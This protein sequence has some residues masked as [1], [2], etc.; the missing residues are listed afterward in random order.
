MVKRALPLLFLLLTSPTFGAVYQIDI[1]KRLQGREGE[2]KFLLYKV[3]K[4][5][6]LLKIMKRF[7]VPRNLLYE[8][9]KLNKIKNPNRIYAGQVIKLPSFRAERSSRGR[10]L[11]DEIALLKRLGKVRESGILFTRSGK[12][13]LKENPLFEV[14]GENFVIDLSGKIGKRVREELKEA[15]FSVVKGSEIDSLIEKALS[16][17]FSS[18]EK[19]GKLILGE[20]DVL[21]YKFDFMGY[22]FKTGQRI[23]INKTPDTPPQLKRL[24]EAYGIDLI[25]PQ[26]RGPKTKEG[27]G[28]LLIVKGGGLT[29]INTVVKVLTG[30]GGDKTGLGLY[31]PDFKVYAVYDFVDPETKVKLELSG[32]R[33]VVLTGNL[34]YDLKKVLT[35]IPLANKEVELVLYEPPLSKGRRSTFKIKGLLVSTPKR[36]WF[37]ID[38]VD[39]PQ[40]LPY[41]NSRGV[42]VMVY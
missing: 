38:R 9:V 36:D 40:E 26:Y 41:L 20:K 1:F 11:K 24:L 7:K 2:E 16:L 37:L 33:V 31:F 29:K 25:Q 8:V 21:V 3:K 32:N 18:V 6:T 12:V 42:N 4:G 22:D 15:G 19:N 35:V 34:L 17:N 5:D 39:K 28:R 23:V 10:G 14:N 30:K 27:W 13:S